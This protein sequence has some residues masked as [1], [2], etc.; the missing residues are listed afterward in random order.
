[1]IRRPGLTVFLPGSLLQNSPYG[2]IQPS[3][4]KLRNA[5]LESPTGQNWRLSSAGVY[6]FR[7]RD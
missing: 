1:M 6:L 4:I 3:V 5:C 2:K 7:L